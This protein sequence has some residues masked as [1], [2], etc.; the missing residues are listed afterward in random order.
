MSN[1]WLNQQTKG[2]QFI[3]R[4]MDLWEGGKNYADIVIASSNLVFLLHLLQNIT[5]YFSHE[6]PEISEHIWGKEFGEHR[7]LWDFSPKS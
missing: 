4:L 6:Y 1:D 7:N 3:K 5:G 2:D